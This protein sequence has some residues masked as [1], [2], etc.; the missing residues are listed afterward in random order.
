MLFVNLKR[1][2]VA[3]HEP[4]EIFKNFSMK[5]VISEVSREISIPIEFGHPDWKFELVPQK[6]DP[7][8]Y[9]CPVQHIFSFR[10]IIIIYFI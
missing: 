7:I 8:L 5:T 2:L 6:I 4:V 3:E 9:S 1:N 10:R